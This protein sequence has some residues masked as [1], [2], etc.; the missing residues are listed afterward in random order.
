MAPLFAFMGEVVVFVG[1]LAQWYWAGRPSGGIS[2]GEV[3][4][5]NGET[6]IIAQLSFYTRNR[7][8][9][10]KICLFLRKRYSNSMRINRLFLVL[11]VA[12]FAVT[13]FAQNHQYVD[14]GLPS[15]TL[16][17]TCNIG[18]DTPQEAGYFFAWGEVEPRTGGFTID[19]YKWK[20]E[21]STK[22]SLEAEDDA[23]TVLWGPEWQIP[24][25]AQQSELTDNRYTRWTL[26]TKGTIGFKITSRKNGK[27]IFIPLPGFYS[28]DEIREADE[29]GGY[30]LAENAGGLNN[31]SADI[32]LIGQMNGGEWMNWGSGA[33]ERWYGQPIRPVRK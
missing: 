11:A 25:G 6:S 32:L 2:M 16:W 12:L 10:I 18:A 28:G 15:G 26:V 22:I 30:W 8:V 4:A 14:L 24:S 19:N 33:T 13:A 27:S 7:T 17:A 29:Y 3:V 21:M 31:A 20:D 5:G 23:A 9:L 1:H